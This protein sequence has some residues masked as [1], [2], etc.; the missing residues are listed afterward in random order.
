MTQ[1]LTF[2]F[3]ILVGFSV[4]AAET[5]VMDDSARNAAQ[6]ANAFALDLYRQQASQSGN[7]VF[8]PASVQIA[9]AMAAAGAGG[10]TAAQMNKVLGLAGTDPHAAEH[11]LL[12][13]LI[14]PPNNRT[15]IPLKISNNLWVSDKFEIKPDYVQRLKQSYD[16]AAARLNFADAAGTAKV[17]NDT[18]AKQT[19]D[20]IKDLVP[21]SAIDHMTR[22]I[23]TNAVHFKADWAHKFEPHATR[24]QA[25]HLS[26]T[27][28]VDV[29][30]MQ[31]TFG[32]KLYEDD[33]L[34]AVAL[35]YA[36][37]Q[38]SMWAVAPK[39]V[40]G[41]G[42]VEKRIVDLPKWIE[43][44]KNK[45]VAIALP[46]FKFESQLSLPKTLAAMGMPD[47]FDPAK[48]DFTGMSTAEG[49]FIGDVIHKAMIDVNE[50]G[51]EAAAATAV[52]MK[53]TAA[54]IMDDPTPFV[55]DRPFL[56]VLRHDP[57]GAIL[58]MAR[59]ADPRK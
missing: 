14:T 26:P 53:A 30:M 31:E 5:R 47:A 13:A 2:L 35:P 34:Q 7:L 16:T 12:M 32:T 33:Q 37:G 40:D 21:P 18:V 42:A 23:L 44:A 11:A 10:E 41:L 3:A 39:A 8:S 52:M 56:V 24:D 50:A 49:L 36:Y 15:P 45:Q 20:K 27:E 1:S 51:T 28:K 29:K 43:G 22:L 6:A 19:N 57:T 59:V 4:A 58:F 48:A 17:I 9:L 25:F 54:P 55:A 46:K 38:F